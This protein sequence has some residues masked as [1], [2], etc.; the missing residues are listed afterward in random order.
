M[1]IVSSKKELV[2]QTVNPLSQFNASVECSCIIGPAW[3]NDTKVNESKVSIHHRLNIDS[4]SLVMSAE[5]VRCVV[6]ILWFV[7][8]TKPTIDGTDTA[9]EHTEGARLLIPFSSRVLQL[10]R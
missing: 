4:T 8:A 6:N 1:S 9:M 2:W 7:D 5:V 3:S 10:F